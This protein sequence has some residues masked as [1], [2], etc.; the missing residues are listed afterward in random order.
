MMEVEEGGGTDSPVLRMSPIVMPLNDPPLEGSVH[1]D[2][3]SNNFTIDGQSVESV[4][5]LLTYINNKKNP[6]TII[7]LK[8]SVPTI[9]RILD[10]RVNELNDKDIF[11]LIDTCDNPVKS[12]NSN[13]LL[14]THVINVKFLADRFRSI[15]SPYN[16]SLAFVAFKVIN[17]YKINTKISPDHESL[18]EALNYRISRSKTEI[19]SAE[20]ISEGFSCLKCLE[21]TKEVLRLLR[22]LGEK[23]V[24][25]KDND[26]IKCKNFMMVILSGQ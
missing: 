2:D 5:D 22:I 24:Q 7:E 13:P 4:R 19:F 8:D 10:K 16:S 15:S 9:K 6:S 3:Y 12:N 17:N 21:P 20:S 14:L 23:A 11:K 25:S 26:D 1:L 18:L